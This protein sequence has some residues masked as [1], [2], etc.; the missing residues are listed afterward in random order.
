M[1]KICFFL[2]AILHVFCIALLT[3]I[4]FPIK[5]QI[6]PART[7]VIDISLLETEDIPQA[8]LFVPDLKVW[9]KH[10]RAPASFPG[11]GS[12]SGSAPGSRLGQTLAGGPQTTP[13]LFSAN[14]RL[15]L[16]SAPSSAFSLV[17][18]APGPPVTSAFTTTIKNGKWLQP[19]EYFAGT[20]PS[21][22][23]FNETG[24]PAG[25]LD[26][27]IPFTIQDKETA[28]WTQNILARIERN[29]IIPTMARV[30][31][32]GQV[33][34]MLTIDHN[35]NQLSLIVEKSSSQEA[36]DQAALSAM[37]VSLPFPPLPENISAQ[38]FVFHFVFTYNA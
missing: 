21:G 26:S 22:I 4:S 16:K 27:R 7:I 38:T 2:S 18:P 33:E 10:G 36:L 35:G 20:Y 5:T 28:R 14:G 19:G 31:L 29:W 1:R 34:I 30:G 23:Q 8:P 12:G 3:Q 32:T 9:K 6:L 37:K 17:L 13:P 25:S 24:P 15:K 11:F